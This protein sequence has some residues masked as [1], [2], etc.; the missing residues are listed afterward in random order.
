MGWRCVEES[1]SVG[2]ICGANLDY[3][4]LLRRMGEQAINVLPELGDGRALIESS[5]QITTGSEDA[6]ITRDPTLWRMDASTHR[7]RLL[8]AAP[9]AGTAAWL[10]GVDLDDAL[11]QVSKPWDLSPTP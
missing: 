6:R 9:G 1:G 2:N 3:T 4:E 8:D 11:T 10:F 5:I 7:L